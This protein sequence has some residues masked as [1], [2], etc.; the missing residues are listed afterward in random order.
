MKL[1]KAELAFKCTE[2]EDEVTKHHAVLIYSQYKGSNF[3]DLL[4]N[5]TIDIEKEELKHAAWLFKKS[6]IAL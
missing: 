4:K 1:S 2:G 3:N 6:L 5:A